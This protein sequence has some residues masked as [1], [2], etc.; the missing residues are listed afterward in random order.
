MGLNLAELFL[1]LA[2][3]YGIYRALGPLR[4]RLERFILGIF[5]PSSRNVIDVKPEDVKK[6]SKED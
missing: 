5:D 3:I 1:L 4:R 6:D 2:F